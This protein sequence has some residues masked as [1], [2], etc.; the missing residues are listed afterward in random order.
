ME[1]FKRVIQKRNLILKGLALVCI[2]LNIMFYVIP[3]EKTYEV[4][5]SFQ[6]GLFEGLLFLGLLG[7]YKYSKALKDEQ[8][9]KKLYIQE[10][11]ERKM[12]IKQKVGQSSLITIVL[13]LVMIT[14]VSAYMDMVVTKTLICVIYGILFITLI[15]KIYYSKKY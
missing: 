5:I 13:L 1:E 7:I 9:L 10:H 12:M 6:L 8:M 3:F 2:I 14:C 11:D 15:L 4:G